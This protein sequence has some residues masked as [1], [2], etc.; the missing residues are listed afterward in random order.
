MESP[1]NQLQDGHR[2]GAAVPDDDGSGNDVGREGGQAVNPPDPE[3]CA[4]SAPKI[5]TIATNTT[6][7][8]LAS[9]ITPTNDHVPSPSAVPA[10]RPSGAG[11]GWGVWVGVLLGVADPDMVT[12]IWRV[13]RLLQLHAT[14]WFSI[15]TPLLPCAAFAEPST[16]CVLAIHHN[17]PINT[18]RLPTSTSHIEST[19][20]LVL[21]QSHTPTYTHSLTFTPTL[22][23]THTPKRTF[24]K[25]TH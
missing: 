25:S 16:P 18:Q 12:D 6:R 5:G 17:L 1:K 9:G 8:T 15:R 13:S 4:N 10:P 22:S 19:L 21:A 23:R 14:P 24:G 3:W 7:T 11:D 20:V 2:A